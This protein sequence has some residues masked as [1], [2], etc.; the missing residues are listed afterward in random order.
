MF[1]TKHLTGVAT[2]KA[3]G[4][5]EGALEAVISSFGVVDHGG[6][7][8]EASA[9]TDGQECLM[10]WSHDWDRPIGKGAIRVEEDRAIFAGQLWLDTDDGLQ[11][12]RKIRN[13]GTLQEYSWGFRVLDAN[14]VERDGEM[15]RVI[16]RAE[17]FEASPVLKGEG[18]NTGTLSLK[19]LTEEHINLPLDEHAALVLAAN[20]TLGQRLRSH[21]DLKRQ[22]TATQK[23]GRVL[24]E[25]NRERIKSSAASARAMA[26]D[27]DA[28]H[29]ETAPPPKDDGKALLA[30]VIQAQKTLARLNGVAA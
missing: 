17:L 27:L 3:D 20:A 15:F 5:G 23:E 7:I 10:C 6:D 9:F 11:A 22:P 14:F 18:M 1:E 13:A 4:D 30:I 19:A 26:D 28:L 24:S 12:F 8:V 25:A 29:A 2:L 21:A 16:T